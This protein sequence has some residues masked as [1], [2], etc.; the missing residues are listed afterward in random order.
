MKIELNDDSEN[1]WGRAITFYVD[2]DGAK[3]LTAI[4]NEFKETGEITIPYFPDRKDQAMPTDQG[5]VTNG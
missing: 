1:E 5:D 3:Y 2:D 4:A